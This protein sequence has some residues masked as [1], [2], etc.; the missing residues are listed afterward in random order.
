MGL[1]MFLYRKKYIYNNER[2]KTVIKGVKGVND[3]RVKEITEEVYY[4]RKANQIHQ[5]FVDNVQEGE[6]DCKEYYVEKKQLEELLSTIKKVLEDRNMAH[7]L[8]PTQ[9][10]FFFGATEYDEWYWGNLEETKKGLEK[11]LAED[12]E[13]FNFYYHSSW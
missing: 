13:G 2:K 9:E 12:N 1:D 5:W 3:K 6:D 11:I 8:L 7:I 10:G 4:W